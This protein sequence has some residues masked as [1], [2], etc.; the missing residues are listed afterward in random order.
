M[1]DVKLSALSG[2]GASPATGDE[3]YIRDIS[4]AAADESKRITIADL[5]QNIPFPATQSA[6]ADANVLDDHEEGTWTPS[7]ADASLSTSAEGAQAHDI[8]VG[9]YDKNGRVVHCQFRVRS[10][11]LGDLTTTEQASIVGLPFT[12]KNTGNLTSSLVVGQ[13]DTM[14]LP[15]ASE[16]VAGFILNNNTHIRL[17]L[18][19]STS[20]STA[21]LISEYA[22]NGLLDATISY[23][24]E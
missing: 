5:M 12:S 6:S 22:V 3:I 11:N 9:I 14:A 2:L 13:G 7:L 15:N 23:A 24:V 18:W 16:T 17:Q 1:A 8:Q 4:E 19:D 20:G 10:T 21:L